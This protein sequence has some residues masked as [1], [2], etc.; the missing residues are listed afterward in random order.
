MRLSRAASALAA[1]ALA[2]AACNGGSGGTG[3]G[4]AGGA[5]VHG[6]PMSTFSLFPLGVSPQCANCL[7]EQC[8]G[9]IDACANDARC[10]ACLSSDTYCDFPKDFDDLKTCA[11]GSCTQDCYPPTDYKAPPACVADG[12]GD[13]GPANDVC[14]TISDANACNPLV[15]SYACNW[16]TG[17]TCDLNPRLPGIG[18]AQGFA[19]FPSARHHV[20]EACGPIEGG[21][22][23]GLT[24]VNYQCTRFCCTN[25]DCGTGH[26]DSTWIHERY[27]TYDTTK[28][29]LGVCV[30]T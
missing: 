19:C 29:T 7:R 25:L 4:G 26:C 21:C 27:P 12:I 16:Q 14:F 23:F 6:C 3:G 11:H 22:H 13:L 24:C 18:L 8:C 10:R 1:A 5:P 9:Q 28:S 20:C 15:Q 2:I 17:A 30:K